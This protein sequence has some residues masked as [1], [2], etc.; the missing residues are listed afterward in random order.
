VVPLCSLVDGGAR[1]GFACADEYED[2][3]Q[4]PDNGCEFLP[5]PDGIYVS[6]PIN[7]GVDTGRCGVW[8]APCAT[9]GQALLRASSDGLGAVWVSAGLYRESIALVDGVSVLGGYNARTWTREPSVHVTTITGYT[10]EP[11]GPDRA[12]VIAESIV[13]PTELSGFT[14]NAEPA[15]ARG[16]SVGLWV[17]NPGAEF[18]VRN[19]V[20]F[21][22]DGGPGLDGSAGQAGDSGADGD[23]GSDSLRRNNCN[24]T[25]AATAGGQRRCDNPGNGRTNVSGGAGGNS[26]CPAANQRNGAGANGRGPGRGTGGQG[27]GHFLGTSGRCTVGLSPDAQPG[28]AG[29]S[30]ADGAGGEGA[31][32][33]LGTV[34]PD[35]GQWRGEQGRDGSAGA[36]GGGGGGGGSAAGVDA[37]RAGGGYYYGATGGSSGSG[38][39]A[40]FSGAGGG[41]GGGSFAILMVYTDGAPANPNAMPTIS[42]N[43]LIRGRGGNGGQGGVG[44]GGG[45]PGVGGLGG[46]G[47]GEGAHGFCML[48]A[49]I[50]APGG[51]GGHG[52]GGGGGAGGS[53][54][55]LFVGGAGGLDPGYDD[56]N[57]FDL[58]EDVL[59]SGEGGVGGSSSNV[60]IG[61]GVD[62]T[63][64]ESGQVADR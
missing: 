21:G 48:D 17:G 3:D 13:T 62:G 28:S 1:C 32:S 23:D 30:G 35:A 45:D 6:S 22:S 60:R 55:D 9:I 8:D 52:G 29:S 47:L 2:A 43:R 53:S 5:N 34:D 58:P 18:L 27:G 41:P 19:N 25:G 24:Y 56:Q 38:G 50:G 59:T 57:S 44:G 51:R 63:S 46:A 7:G 4:I 39:C 42:D 20:I 49:A 16:N 10:A 37:T 54:W 40:G 61:P 33:P 15:A 36:H 26:T 11:E 64:G 14:I 31:T 12:T